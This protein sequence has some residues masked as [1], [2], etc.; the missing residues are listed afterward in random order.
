[1]SQH[2]EPLD[3][4]FIADIPKSR[5]LYEQ[6][7]QFHWEYY[8]EL[9]YQ[10]NRI[11][12]SLKSS[13]RERAAPF[14]LSRWQRVVK[15]KY[16]LHPLGT[17]GSVADPGGRFNVGEIDPTRYPV[18]PALYV[19]SD[20]GTALAELLGRGTSS[21]LLTPEEVA[22]TKPDSIAAVSV[23]G[24][25]DAVLDIR[26]DGSLIAFVALIKGFRLTPTLPS[27][28]RKVGFPL[29]IIKTVQ[30]LS[31]VLHASDWRNWPVL[32]DAPAACQIF[33]RIAL[34]AQVEGILYKSVLTEKPCLAIYHQ[35]FHNSSSYIEL[36][37]PVP[38]ELT[39]RRLDSSNCKLLP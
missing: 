4:G 37:D 20:K 11:Y 22:L 38:P 34:D 9:A 16:A 5:A 36:D 25:L 29:K 35:N 7:R 10:R 30:E 19:A 28:A 14:E 23:S 21:G 1:M 32:Y 24:H 3:S 13:L 33:G 15:F 18:F 6:L 17:N 27:K 31:R 8:S 2:D 12:D 26:D 39:R